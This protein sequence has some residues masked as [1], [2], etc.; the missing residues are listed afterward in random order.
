MYTNTD[1]ERERRTTVQAR[2]GSKFLPVDE[3]SRPA[4][5]AGLLRTYNTCIL[6]CLWQIKGN[7]S[8]ALQALSIGLGAVAVG[9]EYKVDLCTAVFHRT[10]GLV[11]YKTKKSQFKYHDY[12][13]YINYCVLPFCDQQ[14][15][16]SD[17][18]NRARMHGRS[19]HQPFFLQIKNFKKTFISEE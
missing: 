16:I 5:S 14:P 3:D 10:S 11:C 19:I 7:G 18:M 4:W 2:P 6:C 8:E 15:T 12:V 1:R 9:A 13:L 17:V